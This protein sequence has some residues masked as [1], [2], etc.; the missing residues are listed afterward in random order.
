MTC[1][2]GTDASPLYQNLWLLLFALR[3]AA[4]RLPHGNIGLGVVVRMGALDLIRWDGRSPASPLSAPSS[5]RQLDQDA[6]RVS[7][8]CA[9][10]ADVSKSRITKA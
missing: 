4:D 9:R 3:R 7:S 8:T 5:R 2:P 6:D 1:T 10:W